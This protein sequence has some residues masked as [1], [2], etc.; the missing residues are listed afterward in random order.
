MN[1]ILTFVDPLRLNKDLFMFSAVAKDCQARFVLTNSSYG[2]AKKAA[3]LK[4]S[5]TR[6]KTTWPELDWI[7]ADANSKP[8]ASTSDF[9][10]DRRNGSDLAFLQY[11]SGSTANPKGVMISFD[12]LKHNL[13]LIKTALQATDETVVVSWLPQYHDM[14]LIGAYLGI[15]YNGGFG[16]YMSPADFIQNP[17]LWVKLMARYRATHIQGPNFAFKL[18]SRKLQLSEDIDLS[19]IQHVL[20]GAEP[21]DLESL[22]LFYE[23]MK[24]YGLKPNVINPTYGLAEHTVYVCG[25]SHKHVVVDKMILEQQNRVVEVES[26]LGKAIISCGNPSETA[27]LDLRIVQLDE[28]EELGE[29]QVGEIWIDSPSKA[30]GYYGL[31]EKS[32]ADFHAVLPNSER[33]YLRTGDLGFMH[34]GELYVCGRLKDLII[35]RGKNHFPQDLEA[36]V[37]SIP[38]IRPGCSAAVQTSSTDLVI[39]AEVRDGQTAHLVDTCKEIREKIVGEHGVP[40]SAVSL[41]HSRTICKTTSGKIARSRCKAAFLQN[42]L[43]ELIRFPRET[44]S[45]TTTPPVPPPRATGGTEETPAQVLASLMHHV[46]ELGGRPLAEC[47]PTT[48]LRSLGLDSMSLTQIRGVI[49]NQ[50][51]VSI[52][53]SIMY[54]EATT[55]NNLYQVI[56]PQVQINAP[57]TPVA[58]PEKP[59]CCDKCII[60]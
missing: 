56:C 47:Q 5:F 30:K 59:S 8:K 29:D 34:Q 15:I 52:D 18:V 1:R 28:M 54:D 2:Y 39:I 36:S 11:T 12:N 32:L 3:A 20:N 26:D 35:I 55:I 14:G 60:S 7:T 17:S 51:H 45:E 9:V 48:S 42:Q 23:A 37:E 25:G 27:D 10:L 24:P 4:D 19:S 50:Y 46:S 41:V 21:I 22:N 44:T 33:T 31:K 6:S 57:P 38:Q 43:E 53:E 40:V 13:A 16:V 49:T 58:T